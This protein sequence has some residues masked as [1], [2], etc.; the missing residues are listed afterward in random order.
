MQQKFNNDF[1]SEEK[2]TFYLALAAGKKPCNVIASNAGHCLF[3]GIASQSQA[4]KVAQSLLKKEMFTGW[5]IRTLSS[6]EIRY[7]PISYHNG[8]VWPHDNA[9]I[10]YGF[11]KYGLKD[12]V[13]KIAK[14]MFDTSFFSEGRRLP[15]L[16]CGFKRKPGEAPVNYPVACSP[17]AWSVATVFLII[18]ALLGLDINEHQ[19]I[20][21]FYRPVLP[22]FI[23]MMLIKQLK[24][25]NYK[26][27]LELIRTG[28]SVSIQLLNKDAPVKL[29]IIY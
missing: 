12:E 5:G 26:L 20:I 4:Q 11:S 25:K 27:N 7:N 21:R 16:F 14:G 22:E 15:E 8:S 29:E 10:A 6:E 28:D 1:W 18:Q 24:F 9:L 19:N 23:E 13:I 17:Q 3:S 2:S